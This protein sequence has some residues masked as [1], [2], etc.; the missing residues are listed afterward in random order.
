MVR[1]VLQMLSL[2]S[3]AEVRQVASVD[4]E[5]ISLLLQLRAAVS[6]EM[7]EQEMQELVSSEMRGLVAARPFLAVERRQ[8][9]LRQQ[10]EAF[11][12]V[13]AS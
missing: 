6:L 2:L 10:Q 8:R 3:G 7:Q 9:R 12:V 1:E 11:S 5:I 4:S 13:A